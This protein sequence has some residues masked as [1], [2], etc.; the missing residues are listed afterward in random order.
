MVLKRIG[1][2]VQGVAAAHG[3]KAELVKDSSYP[4]MVNHPEQAAAAA[5]AARSL[6]G[7]LTMDV[8]E[9]GLPDVG[10]EDFA[11]YLRA[12][13]GAFMFIGS[14]QPF[15]TGLAAVQG[16]QNAARTNCVPRG[17]WICDPGSRSCI[18]AY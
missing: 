15:M 6:D 11:Y 8:S 16:M 12:K 13:P 14:F 3:C 10:S 9:E 17:C 7:V 18:P 4:C 1:E 2:I 5:R